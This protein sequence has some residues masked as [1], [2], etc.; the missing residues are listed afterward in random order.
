MKKFGV[1]TEF[2][3]FGIVGLGGLLVDITFYYLLQY[4]SLPHL[5][6]RALS[7][8][9]AV[10]TNWLLYRVSTFGERKKRKM[11]QQWLEFMGTCIIGFCLSWGTYYLL[12][13]FLP[14]VG[15]TFFDQYRFVALF[16]G[17][18]LASVFNYTAS[19]LFVYSDKR[20]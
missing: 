20:S 7:F 15:F 11:L 17:M 2:L 3:H 4:L 16:P 18:A 8:W 1:F 5:H 9:P 10:T 6:A 14:S 12:T 19:T 13:I